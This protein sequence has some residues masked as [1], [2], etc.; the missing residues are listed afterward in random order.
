ME[1]LIYIGTKQLLV[2]NDQ[3]IFLE[4]LNDLYNLF[5]DRIE[6]YDVY[7]VNTSNNK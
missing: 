3:S 4:M 5:D 2:I 6:N 1:K 7:K